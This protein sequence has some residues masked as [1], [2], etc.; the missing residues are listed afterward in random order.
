MFINF[1][2]INFSCNNLILSLFSIVSIVL[3]FNCFI[4]IYISISGLYFGGGVFMM[5]CFLPS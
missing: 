1:N 3:V 2:F 5:A 4:N